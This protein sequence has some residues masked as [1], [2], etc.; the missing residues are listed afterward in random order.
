MHYKQGSWSQV[1]DDPRSN[2]RYFHK[3]IQTWCFCRDERYDGSYKKLSL[4]RDVENK[5][6]F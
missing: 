6:D 5:L 1:C 4:S 2:C 3:D